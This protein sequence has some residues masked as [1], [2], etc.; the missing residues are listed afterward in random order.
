M[1]IF[2]QPERRRDTRIDV[3]IPLTLIWVGDNGKEHRDTI[4][5]E[6]INAYGCL[7]YANLNI[8]PE[9]SIDIM[10]LS[11]KSKST[12]RVIWCGET[13]AEG[14]TYLGV[15]LTETNPDFWGKQVEEELKKEVISD[16]WVD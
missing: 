9:T 8:P 7:F 12:A 16:T 3:H 13:D 2:P 4:Q 1:S 11:T 15:E 6:T 5:T 10:N 14:R